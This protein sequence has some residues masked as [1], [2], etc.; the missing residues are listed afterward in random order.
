MKARGYS[1]TRILD[2]LALKSMECNSYT[3]C[4]W[5]G[6]NDIWP[7]QINKIHKEQYS[8]S[9]SLH[10]Q[11]EFAKLYLYQLSYANGLVDSYMT[12]FCDI[13]RAKTNENRFKCVAVSYNGHPR[14]KHTYKKIWW[15]KR[16]MISDYLFSNWFLTH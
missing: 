12:R 14:Y 1:N 4:V 2:L 11:K 8:H 15:L 3:S 10:K 13:K 16:Q 5:M 6:W 7:F 9:L